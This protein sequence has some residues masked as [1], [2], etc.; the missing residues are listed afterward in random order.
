MENT[1]FLAF[2]TH[3]ISWTFLVILCAI[4][5]GS[6]WVYLGCISVGITIP[7]LMSPVEGTTSNDELLFVSLFLIC[8]PILGG[9]PW[10]RRG[11]NDRTCSFF[12]YFSYHLLYLCLTLIK[13]KLL[14]CCL[15]AIIKNVA[16]CIRLDTYSWE[17]KRS[18]I[19]TRKISQ[20]EA[21]GMLCENVINPYKNLLN[22]IKMPVWG[23]QVNEQ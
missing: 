9:G 2:M 22:K 21:P 13:Q 17:Q 10:K 6:A 5:K 7:T 15:M 18:S 11:R 1:C 4:L 19:S 14:N 8:I 23:M 16:I 3:K 20:W 12:P